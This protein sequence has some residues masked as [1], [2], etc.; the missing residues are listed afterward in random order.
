ME[1]VK[2]GVFMEHIFENSTKKSGKERVADGCCIFAIYGGYSTQR[3][4]G[5]KIPP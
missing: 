4:R 1:K 2:R 3:P 5:H